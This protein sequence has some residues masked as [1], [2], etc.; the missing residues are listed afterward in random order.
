MGDV[1]SLAAY[2]K[3]KGIAAPKSP[4]YTLNATEAEVSVAVNRAAQVMV[5][6]MDY[7]GKTPYAVLVGYEDQDGRVKLLKDICCYPNRETFE[8]DAGRKSMWTLALVAKKPLE[9]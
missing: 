5:K 9:N 8:M 6:P 7:R 4:Y 3:R 2:K 1:I